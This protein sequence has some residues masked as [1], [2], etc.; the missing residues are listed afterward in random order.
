MNVPW[1]PIGVQKTVETLLGVSHVAAILASLSTVMDIHVMVGI[2]I[3]A[4]KFIL[5]A[6]DF[7]TDINE[8]SS[9]ATNSC[10]HNCT[11]TLGSYTCQC[12]AGYRLNGDGQTCTG[13]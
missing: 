7:S 11:N 10:Q 12:N 4:K 9:S 2:I 1:G 8:C 13:M 6:R 5:C 3:A